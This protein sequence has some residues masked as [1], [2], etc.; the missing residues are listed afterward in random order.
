MWNNLFA[1]N[2]NSDGFVMLVG[3]KLDLDGDRDVSREQAEQK[4]NEL[5]IKYHQI[6]A[7]TGENIEQV[8]LDVVETTSEKTANGKILNEVKSS[9]K[10]QEDKSKVDETDTKLEDAKSGEGVQVVSDNVVL[11]NE[12]IGVSKDGERRVCC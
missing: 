7:K 11:R 3:N 10:E 1:E 9:I 6:S 4:A 5:G 12:K 8:F 2:K